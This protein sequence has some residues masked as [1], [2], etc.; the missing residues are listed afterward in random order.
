MMWE[1]LKMI[2]CILTPFHLAIKIQMSLFIRIQ[3]VLQ[4]QVKVIHTLMPTL[5]K[6]QIQLHVTVVIVLLL[7]H[8]KVVNLLKVKIDTN[9]ES[10]RQRKKLL[11]YFYYRNI[12]N[13]IEFW[14]LYYLFFLF[15]IS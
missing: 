9:K 15:F 7:R 10:K 4:H 6:I 8:H 14:F 2:I 13:Y 11:F 1:L 3:V 12:K 5:I